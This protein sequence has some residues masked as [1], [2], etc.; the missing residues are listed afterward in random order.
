MS[1][2]RAELL[3]IRRWKFVAD[4]VDRG[5]LISGLIALATLLVMYFVANNIVGMTQTLGATLKSAF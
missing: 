1:Q 3:K 2:V 4:L 5:T